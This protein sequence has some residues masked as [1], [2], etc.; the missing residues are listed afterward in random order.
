MN[1]NVFTEKEW[2]T[3]GVVTRKADGGLIECLSDHLTAFSILL[4]PTPMDRVSGYHEYIL[5]LISYVG[6]GLSILGLS[7]TVLLY[8]LF[9]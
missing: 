4:D 8:S 2:S 5:R 1:L 9:R 6:S 7:I 3:K